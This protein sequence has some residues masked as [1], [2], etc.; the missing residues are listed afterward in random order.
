ML[1]RG[2]VGT[3]AAP[4]YVHLGTD[5]S[6]NVGTSLL[7]RPGPSD[8]NVVIRQYQQHRPTE[9][10]TECS[11]PRM[12]LQH[13]RYLLNHYRIV[14]VTSYMLTIS[15]FLR[16]LFQHHVRL[17]VPRGTDDTDTDLLAVSKAKAGAVGRP[18]TAS[19]Y[20]R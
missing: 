10:F 2:S 17:A 12:L 7:A 8:I 3:L 16:R 13:L 5:E 19:C 18:P 4:P 9:C 14:T 15:T 1:A 20:S 11:L 6:R